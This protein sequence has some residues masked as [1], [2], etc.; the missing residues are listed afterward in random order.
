[1]VF[2]SCSRLTSFTVYML[3]R[4]HIP[5]VLALIQL[6]SGSHGSSDHA[7]YFA[8]SAKSL[9]EKVGTIKFAMNLT[10]ALPIFSLIELPRS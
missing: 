9:A 8:F 3:E 5:D 6:K 4:T 1:M 10:T 2:S 7:N